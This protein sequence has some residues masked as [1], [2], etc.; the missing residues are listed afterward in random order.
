MRAKGMGWG[1]ARVL[2]WL[3]GAG[4]RRSRRL[5]SRPPPP[6][7]PPSGA[8]IDPNAPLD[9]MPDLGVEWP[10]LATPD[11]RPRPTL[12]PLPPLAG[13]RGRA[14]GARRRGAGRRR[15]RGAALSRSRS[16]GSTRSRASA[17][18]R[19]E[20]DAQSALVEG[21][22]RDRQRRADR[23][24]HPR[25]RRI[26]DRIAP[27]RKAITTPTVEP[28]IVG[29]RRARSA[30]IAAR[31]PGDALSLR[32]GRLA[33]A[34]R[35]GER[36]GGA[37]RGVRGQGGR[38]GGR[39]AGHR[40]GH[41]AADR[42]WRAGLCDRDHRRAGDRA[43]SR[44]RAGAAQPAGDPGAGRALRR[45]PGQRD[46]ALLGAPRRADRALQERRPL[47]AQRGRRSAPRAGRDR[48]GRAGRGED[49]AGRR[50]AA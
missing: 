26:A 29:R 48:A 4:V 19:R 34:R 3:R 31:D 17:A 27:R 35:R 36:G 22:K 49:G 28:D 6:P 38:C 14:R 44:A 47:R 15:G 23:P 39:R 24:P 18:I 20:F 16:P 25:R 5:P 2:A 40:R 50:G 9:A 45:D 41:R 37:A 33:R 46:A 1:A 13:E 21:R 30:I 12:A 7:P 43:R 11:P 42:A 32:S 8:E 10:D